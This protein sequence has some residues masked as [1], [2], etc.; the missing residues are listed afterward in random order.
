[1]T[2][3][4]KCSA[5]LIKYVCWSM[6]KTSRQ[7][8]LPVNGDGP[9]ISFL[10]GKCSAQVLSSKR[11][12]FLILASNAIV[13]ISASGVA[14]IL[15]S[16]GHNNTLS[17][18]GHL[19]PGLPDFKPPDF[20]YTQDNITITSNKI[21]SVSHLILYSFI[22]KPEKILQFLVYSGITGIRISMI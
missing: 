21:F 9:Q 13:V 2:C 12:F 7:N 5:A 17:I 20:S 14:A 16:Q 18:T 4:L 22:L 10:A 6:S 3:E 8:Y 15:I 19:K 11:K 1:M